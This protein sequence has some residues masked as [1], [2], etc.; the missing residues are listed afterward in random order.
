MIVCLSIYHLYTY[1]LLLIDLNV[2][3]YS[4]QHVCSQ[5]CWVIYKM[6]HHTMICVIAMSGNVCH[7][8]KSGY[9][10]SIWHNRVLV[11]RGYWAPLVL[12]TIISGFCSLG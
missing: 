7:Q 6:G 2:I 10:T 9:C 5:S 11:Q 4:G 12:Y 3:M 8:K 1:M